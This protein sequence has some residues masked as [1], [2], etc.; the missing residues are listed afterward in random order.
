[1]TKM[2]FPLGVFPASDGR[3]IY[4]IFLGFGPGGSAYGALLECSDNKHE[5]F[6]TVLNDGHDEEDAKIYSHHVGPKNS[7]KDAI[8]QIAAL[9]IKRP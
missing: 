6:V 1:M 2:G 4:Q 7:A 8:Q 5:L 9:I 3:E